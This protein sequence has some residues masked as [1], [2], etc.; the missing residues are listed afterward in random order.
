MSSRPQS[1]GAVEEAAKWADLSAELTAAAFPHFNR[2]RRTGALCDVRIECQGRFFRAHRVVLSAAIPFFASMFNSE[3]REQHSPDVQIKDIQPETLEQIINLVYTGRIRID[4]DNVEEVM[5]AADFLQFH[6]LNQRCSEMLRAAMSAENVL[7][8]RRF[9]AMH[10]S[11]PTS[12]AADR[13]I[14]KHF[15]EIAQT[16]EFVQLLPDEL[17]EILDW[18]ELHVDG[19]EEIFEAAIRWLEFDAARHKEAP[20][21]LK[22]VRMPRLESAFLSDR[23]AAHPIVHANMRCRDLIDEAKDFHLLPDRRSAH[24]TFKTTERCCSEVPGLIYVCGGIDPYSSNS[25][26]EMFDP[27]SGQWTN[28]R[29]MQTNRTRI[30]VAVVNRLLY[31]IGGYNGRERMRT[32]EV[33]DYRRNSWTLA[34]SLEDKRSAMSVAAA[35]E[36][37]L[38]CGGYDGQSALNSVEILDTIRG[39]WLRGPP[40]SVARCAAAA[41]TLDGH[42]YVMGG[43]NGYKVFETAERFDLRAGRWEAVESMRQRRCRH[44]AAA[45]R[46]KIYVAGGYDSVAGQH[47]Q[48]VEIFDPATN[49]WADGPPLLLPRSRTSLVTTGGALYAIGGHD[50]CNP[51]AS[52]EVLVPDGSA[53]ARWRFAKSMQL[54]DGGAALELWRLRVDDEAETNDPEM[55]FG[56]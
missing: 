52:M 21:I 13:F 27:L 8:I 25:K 10:N 7:G 34:P 45:F 50:G 16:K 19:E 23:V 17:E 36:R 9:A 46:G 6:L 38:V 20:K 40:M 4:V 24:K 32:V 31:A 54:H 2:L 47:L 37:I 3:L 51:V 14:R 15:V 11:A 56:E 42:V 22:H 12:G 48:S 53:R 39:S 1:P 18:D 28:A 55:L 29:S 33:F 35:E 43:H 26:V 30:G 49:A 41:A 5:K 44:A